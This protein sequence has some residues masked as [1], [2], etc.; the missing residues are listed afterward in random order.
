M[1]VSVLRVCA[2]EAR[3]RVSEGVREDRDGDE[4]EDVCGLALRSYLTSHPEPG[5]APAPSPSPS[6]LRV[7]AS[8][9]L[10]CGSGQL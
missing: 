5:A 3:K 8:T 10:L 9:G 1:E 4:E 6:S 7:W 2:R